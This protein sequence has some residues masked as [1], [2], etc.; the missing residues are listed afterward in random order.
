MSLV[1]IT[2]ASMLLVT[3]SLKNKN[4]YNNP[5]SNTNQKLTPA[6]TKTIPTNCDFCRSNGAIQIEQ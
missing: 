3:K 5:T 4:H 6:K 2:N 1:Y